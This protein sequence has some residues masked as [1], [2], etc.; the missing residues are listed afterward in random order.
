MQ[1]EECGL[2][3]LFLFTQPSLLSDDY[4]F[5]QV[6]LNL[7]VYK[8]GVAYKGHKLPCKW[9]LQLTTFKRK[10]VQYLVQQP[11]EYM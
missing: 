7:K 11:S 5:K 6:W 4:L 3:S 1:C 10:Q 2:A 9:F 8:R